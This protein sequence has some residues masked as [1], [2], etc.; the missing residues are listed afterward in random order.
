M[1]YSHTVSSKYRDISLF[2][3][4]YILRNPVVIVISRLFSIDIMDSDEQDLVPIECHHQSI[5]SPP[6]A[7]RLR[8]ASPRLHIIN[9]NPYPLSR[10]NVAYVEAK[11]W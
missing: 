2:S 7:S 10:S 1:S 11:D 4:E 6:L 8:Q 9:N 3:Q 5:P